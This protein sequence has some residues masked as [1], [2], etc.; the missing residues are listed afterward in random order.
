MACT[1][2]AD[3]GEDL[4]VWRVAA[5]VLNMQSRTAD[6]VYPLAWGLGEGIWNCSSKKVAHYE[7]PHRESDFDR[8]YEKRI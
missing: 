8:V 6:K 2:N 5:D 4:Q 7:I 3:G 1:E